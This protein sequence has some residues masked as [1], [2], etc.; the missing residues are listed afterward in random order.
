MNILMVVHQFLPRH[1]AGSEVYTYR[2]AQALQAR[3]HHVELFFT[4]IRTN[5]PQY[6]LTRGEFD[7]I[8]YFE[9]VHNRSFASFRHTYCDPEMERLFG[10]VLSATAP[11]VVHLQHLHLH[12]IGYIDIARRRGLPILFTLHEYMLMC[13]RDGLLLRPGPTRCDGPERAAC[14][15]CAAATYAGLGD[16]TG[17]SIF[18]VPLRRLVA[19]LR[20]V[21]GLARTT[22]EVNGDGRAYLAAVDRRRSEIQ[23]ALDAVNLF[24]APSQFLYD[25]FV[26]AGMIRP[27]RII[28]SDYGF[29]AEPPPTSRR[30]QSGMLRVGYIG[31]ISE[32]KG[33]HVIVEAFR[34]IKAPGIECRIYGDLDVFPN[35]KRRLLDLGIPDA[36]CYMGRLENERV[37]AVLA[38]LDLLIVPSLWFENS[39]L[40]IHEAFLAGLPVLTSDCGG[41][42]ELV[43]D[44]RTGLHFRTGDAADLRRQ[45]LR[46][47]HEPD[48]L[49]SLSCHLPAVKTIEADAAHME[50]R[51]GLL[52]QGKTPVC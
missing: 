52:L 6:E 3:G 11:D 40:T 38:D 1:V 18:P 35:Y 22:T 27:E 46:V 45:L 13:L 36:V 9:A 12:S 39:P 17:A 29:F 23:T 2:L 4:E 19:K 32:F 34:E 8:P 26:A 47:L 33:V 44:G 41:M 28:H 37:A 24:V 5:R 51:Y 16:M 10:R 14:A 15:Q 48:L 43:E 7:G 20:P 31:T 21:L 49:A 42:A 25:R 30:K 50:E